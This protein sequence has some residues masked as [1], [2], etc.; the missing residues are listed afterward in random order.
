VHGHDGD[1]GSSNG[2]CANHPLG[3]MQRVEPPT[4]VKDH[5]TCQTGYTLLQAFGFHKVT[6]SQWALNPVLDSFAR[7]GFVVSGQVVGYVR[8]S[9]VDQMNI[10]SLGK[11]SKKDL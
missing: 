5:S 3:L 6:L 8:V 10:C 9:A 11:K 2:S 4:Q 7:A 1:R